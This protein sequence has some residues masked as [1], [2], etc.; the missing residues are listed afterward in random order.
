MPAITEPTTTKSV[1]SPPRS[2]SRLTIRRPA[3]TAAQARR[4]TSSACR[5]WSG[6]MNVVVI[7]SS[8]RLRCD[9]LPR[10]GRGRSLVV[11][12]RSRRKLRRSAD[13]LSVGAAR[14]EPVLVGEDHELHAVADAELHQDPAHVRLHGR[15]AEEQRGAD[16]GVRQSAYDEVHHLALAVGE[17]AEPPRRREAGHLAALHEAIDQ[18]PCHGGREQGV[19]CGDGAHAADDV[20]RGCVL[21]QE[22]AGPGLQG[23]DDVFVEVEG[24]EDDHARPLSARVAGDDLTGRLDAVHL[25]HA[26]VHQDDVRIERSRSGD[27]GGAVGGLARDLDVGLR[28][29]HHRQPF[30]QQVLVVDEQ[31]ADHRASSRGSRATTLN[32][33]PA[34]GPAVSS[35][36]YSATR[37]RIPTSPCPPLSGAVPAGVRSSSTEPSSVTA[38]CSD[39]A[40][41]DR[42]THARVR[43]ACLRLLVSASCTIRY[44]ES[45][46]PSLPVGGAPSIASV[47]CRPAWFISSTSAGR[48]ARLGTGASSGSAPL[49]RSTPTRRR[50]SANACRPVRSI[51]ASARLARSSSSSG[52]SPAPPACM[53]ITP[54][55]WA[56]T[57]WSSRAIR[58]RSSATAARARSLRARSSSRRRD[59]LQSPRTQA[60]ALAARTPPGYQGSSGWGAAAAIA[61]TSAAQIPSGQSSVRP[62]SAARL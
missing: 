26:D 8:F 29:E 53:T 62:R 49:S 45:S 46:T 14:N 50:I 19:A 61:P 11:G 42:R 31:R 33:P 3:S 30:A 28:V 10:I 34:T 39:S 48:P 57:S 56:T 59:Q 13:S 20:R 15:L 2:P 21:E 52:S 12:R 37:S 7:R 54:S 27:S 32:P 23:C 6:C 36:P 18:P 40:D 16:L 4:A 60:S 25:R 47:T 43:P 38:T 41:Q 44:A 1:Q 5:S 55:A 58:A 22:P 24:G 51:V 17:L 35:P 9:D